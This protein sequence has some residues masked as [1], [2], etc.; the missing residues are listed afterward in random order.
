M[1][2]QRG[3]Y[4]SAGDLWLCLTLGEPCPKADYSHIALSVEPGT[5]HALCQ[6]LK[7]HLVPQWQDNTSEGESL[8]L[9]DP[10]G[11][12]LEIH[13]GDLASRLKALESNPYQG[14]EWL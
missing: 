2:W 13:I 8:Y 10:D 6:R 9:L 4:L 3:A 11:Y 7:E 1:K 5:F 12:K 14:L